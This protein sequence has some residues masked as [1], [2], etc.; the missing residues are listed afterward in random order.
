MECKSERLQSHHPCPSLPDIL[1]QAWLTL[2]SP[3]TAWEFGVFFC[4]I[5][6]TK[7][8]RRKDVTERTKAVKPAVQ[9]DKHDLAEMGGT[10]YKMKGDETDADWRPQ[11][12]VRPHP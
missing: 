10:D 2:G 3:G 5:L 11:C 6:T 7:T 12:L 8:Q 9:D 4:R 1:G